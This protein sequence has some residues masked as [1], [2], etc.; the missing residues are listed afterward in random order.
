M[1]R[2]IR[3]VGALVF[4]MATACGGGA[5]SD[6][7]AALVDA[8]ERTADS[9]FAFALTADVR[10]GASD[11]AA[12]QGLAV[13]R[14]ARIGGVRSDGALSLTIQAMG[15]EF[16]ESRFL[17]DDTV[18]LRINTQAIADM[19]G[20]MADPQQLLGM[21]PAA[22]PEEVRDV[23]EAGLNGGWIGIEGAFQPPTEGAMLPDE[24]PLT[25]EDAQA[26]MDGV[27]ERFGDLARSVEEFTS[28]SEVAA[29]EGAGRRFAVAVDVDAVV[30]AFAQVFEDA[31]GEPL[32]P[33]EVEET[34]QDLPETLT[35]IE[36]TVVDRLVTTVTLNLA[37]ML[38]AA[39]DAGSVP[40]EA[41]LTIELSDHGAAPAVER[42]EGAVTISAERLRELF[43]EF[44][45]PMSLAPRGTAPAA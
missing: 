4:L 28:V 42:P 1:V 41:V 12:A 40:E 31:T 23:I 45:G 38:A 13:L 3:A 26:L 19:T 20:G 25:Q 14:S 2:A 18:Y 30:R 9:S 17:D 15:V 8:L 27:R 43:E 32:P 10:D 22:L 6:P 24:T 44:A 7:Q 37:E 33:D 21:L 5:P 11:P 39:G 35:G 34:V 16:A 29:G 36:V